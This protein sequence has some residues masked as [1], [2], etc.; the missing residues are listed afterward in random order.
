MN[1]V[2]Y[3]LSNEVILTC[4]KPVN[5]V[6]IFCLTYYI[7]NLTYSPL[8][9]VLL[10]SYKPST[11]KKR[12]NHIFKPDFYVILCY[13]ENFIIYYFIIRKTQIVFSFSCKTSILTHNGL[14]KTHKNKFLS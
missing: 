4:W 11:K 8:N 2:L 9:L 14:K 12:N 10:N 3:D 7:V 13:Y 6:Y 5:S 1:D